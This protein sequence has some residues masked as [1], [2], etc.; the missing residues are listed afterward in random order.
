MATVFMRLSLFKPF[1][2]NFQIDSSNEKPCMSA[3]SLCVNERLLSESNA[4]ALC[5]THLCAVAASG[6]GRA[7]GHPQT[8]GADGRGPGRGALR[9][10]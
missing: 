4:P 9:Q 1:Y 8:L 3:P 5:L 7:A 2:S 10:P 6:G